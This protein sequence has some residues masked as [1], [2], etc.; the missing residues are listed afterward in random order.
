MYDIMETVA[1]VALNDLAFFAIAA[2]FYLGLSALFGRRRPSLRS[3]RRATGFIVIIGLLA[4]FRMY[5]AHNVAGLTEGTT[6]AV[7][8]ALSA[9][10]IRYCGKR[11]GHRDPFT[12]D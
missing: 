6:T 4:S 9:M 3:Y 1:S 7:V 12:G 5:R 11:V 10:F 2:L 8:T